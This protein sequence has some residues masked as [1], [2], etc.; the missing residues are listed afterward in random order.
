MGKPGVVQTA[1]NYVADV[2]LAAIVLRLQYVSTPSNVLPATNLRACRRRDGKYSH[3]WPSV[4]IKAE[5][6]L[7]PLLPV[8][9]VFL[10]VSQAGKQ[11]KSELHQGLTFVITGLPKE[12]NWPGW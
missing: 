8:Q 5:P 11:E 10:T 9:P 3:G 1:R 12:T 2:A 4:A 6:K 7:T